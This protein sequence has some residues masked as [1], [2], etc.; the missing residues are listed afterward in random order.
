MAGPRRDQIHLGIERLQTLVDLFQQRRAQLAASV[1][2]TEHQWG[3][4]EEVSTEHFM[5]SMFARQRE[6]S[7][8][9]VS[10]TLRQLI[11]KGL[12]ESSAGNT[13]GRQRRYDLTPKGKRTMSELREHR[14][15]AIQRV[16]S[17]LP[18]ESLSAF[19]DFS[20]LLSA[21]LGAL[22][23]EASAEKSTQAS[24]AK[25]KGTSHGQDTL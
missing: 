16:W 22:V 6:S 21:G 19:I 9:A 13:D 2:L 7:L 25:S 24:T 15:D 1:G 12:V 18:A 5:P 17:K 3:V 23:Q 14:E 20:E 10:K 4:L 11:E 8:A